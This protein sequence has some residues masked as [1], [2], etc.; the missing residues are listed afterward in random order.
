M[1]DEENKQPNTNDEAES[2]LDSSALLDAMAFTVFV[3]DMTDNWIRDTNVEDWKKC[4]DEAYKPA[5]QEPHCGDC[6]KIPTPCLRCMA[7]GA[8]AQAK[9]II[10][11]I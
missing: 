2:E 4:W 9:R 8:Y 3:A 5:M 6:V 10:S 1:K 11:I 7:E